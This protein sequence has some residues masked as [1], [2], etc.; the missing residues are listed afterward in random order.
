M[1]PR[2][3]APERHRPTALAPLLALLLLAAACGSPGSVEGEGS[4]GAPAAGAVP[5]V[6]AP[7]ASADPDRATVR[8]ALLTDPH[9][10]DPRDLLDEEGELVV[11]A[12]FDG[13]VD[14]APDGGVEAAAAESWTVEDAGSTYRFLLRADRFHDGSRVTAR[15]HAEALLAA[16]DPERRPYGREGLLATVR[17]VEVVGAREL[18]VRLTRPDPLIL[19]R[20]SDPALVPLPDI[21]TREPEAF[22]RGPVGNGP[23]RMLGP[24]EPGAFIRLGAWREHPRPPRIDELVLQIVASDVDGSR[25]WEDLLDGRL[26]ISPIT[27][28]RR[29]AARDRFGSPLDGRRGPGLHELPL[30]ATYAYG[31]AIDVAPSDD[32]RLRRAIS[33]AIDRRALAAALASAAVE[34]A[35]A[36]LP[37]VV[38]G[39][40]PTCAH[41]QRDVGLARAL[42]EEWRAARPE[43]TPDPRLTITYPRGEGH[44]TIAERVAADIEQVLDLDVRLQAR[45]LGALV[46]LVEE[47][48]APLFRLGLRAPFGGDAAGVGLLGTSFASDAPEN[49]VGWAEPATDEGLA[50]W[51]LGTSAEVVRSVEQRLLDEAVV[52]PLLWTRPDLV[53]TPDV[54]G[55]HLDP[56]GRWWPELLH[57]R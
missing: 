46:R 5:D 24:R 50:G 17:E 47:G 40:Q 10:L 27:P 15:H 16:M 22:A 33:A 6:V 54:R 8:V 25:R 39:W 26:Q 48:R 3:R 41:C 11:R 13:L 37:P 12:L 19:Y 45:D 52:V 21:A 44:V 49:R 18:I 2:R 30:V 29:D 57:L 23:F 34:E 42:V 53:V 36:V 43:G 9:S 55:F 7:G 20:L 1:R 35:T 4:D 38:R 51:S 31:F 56:T 14:V 32:V 28:D